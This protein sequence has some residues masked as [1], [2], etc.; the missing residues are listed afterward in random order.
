MSSSSS[1]TTTTTTTTTTSRRQRPFRPPSV[2]CRPSRLRGAGAGRRVLAASVVCAH[3]RCG[4]SDEAHRP[5]FVRRSLPRPSKAPGTPCVP[6]R[7]HVRR[8]PTSRRRPSWCVFSRTRRRRRR[9]LRLPSGCST[10]T[11]ALRRRTRLARTR[12]CDAASRIAAPFWSLRPRPSPSL[13]L[14]GIR[15]LASEASAER[16]GRRS[17]LLR[18]TRR[19]RRRREVVVTGWP[20]RSRRPSSRPTAHLL[21]ARDIP[22]GCTGSLRRPRRS[23]RAGHV[24]RMRPPAS[25][26]ASRAAPWRQQPGSRVDASSVRETSSP[27]C[28]RNPRV[29]RRRCC[30]LA[31]TATRTRWRDLRRSGARPCRAGRSGRP[32]GEREAPP[33]DPRPAR[34]KIPSAWGRRTRASGNRGT[35][36][37]TRSSVA[38][39]PAAPVREASSRPS[40]S[41]RARISR[42]RSPLG[43]ATP[44][45]HRGTVWSPRAFRSPRTRCWTPCSATPP[46]PSLPWRLLFFFTGSSCPLSTARDWPAPSM[47]VSPFCSFSK[48]RLRRR[49]RLSPRGSPPA[50]LLVLPSQLSSWARSSIRRLP[51]AR[52]F[53]AG[54]IASRTSRVA[55]SSYDPV[56]RSGGSSSPGQSLK[57]RRAS[58]GFRDTSTLL[59]TT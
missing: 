7:R 15:L 5:S 3:C 26:V 58:T 50:V 20:V 13:G 33:R 24:R 34:G 52:R 14:G 54:K 27:R 39:S 22:E 10:P 16:T 45:S 6:C 37:T 44:A 25:A 2:L 29:W 48:P 47:R 53:A 59:T 8:P 36:S 28:C 30:R 41:P 38:I 40:M 17:T 23:T 56:L 55:V 31:P 12:D 49:S 11:N 43:W 51:D 46:R 42:K 32:T 9:R 1:S 35:A 57:E 19:F 18:R 21:P 4:G